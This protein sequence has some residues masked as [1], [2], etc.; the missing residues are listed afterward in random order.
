VL[1]TGGSGFIGSHVV[2]AL[3]REGHQPVIFDL[4]QSPW[5]APGEIATMTGDIAEGEVV[6][7]AVHGCD[8]VIH[9]AAVADVNDVVADPVWAD[10]INVHGTQMVLEAARHEDVERLVYGSTTWVYGN[11]PV[12]GD[13][14]ED[15]PLSLPTHLYTATKLA[16]EMYCRSYDRAHTILRF[17]IPYGPRSR[18]AAVVAAFVGRA[19]RG[20]SLTIAG[21]GLQTRQF[22]YVEDLAEGIV[23]ALR[24]EAAGR[25][26][27]LARDE[28]VSVRQIADAVREL[29]APV[30]VV[31]V[32]ER[33]ADV[34]IGN[35]SSERAAAE[36]GWRATTPFAEGLQRYVEWLGTTN[37]SP[38]AD[39]AARTNGSAATVRR[40]ESAG[41]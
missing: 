35:V 5:H 14:D 19:Q 3:R 21:N 39:D 28:H 26:F 23:A 12:D 22:L 41:L 20:E 16:G 24:P 13:V 38:V 34:H 1:V 8:A 32:A 36:L 27:N 37:G 11:A 10:R 40:Q 25:I 33:P 2:D 17:G 31:H 4:V 29:V 6:R 9:L 15:A 7:R 30:P 18:A